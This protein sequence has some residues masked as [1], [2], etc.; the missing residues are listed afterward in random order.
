MSTLSGA[1]LSFEAAGASWALLSEITGIE[2]IESIIADDLGWEIVVPLT[3]YERS[4][5][6][7]NEN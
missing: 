4:T 5:S 7:K 3:S 2:G 6:L 1:I